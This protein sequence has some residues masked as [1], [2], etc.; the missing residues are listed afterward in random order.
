MIDV[1]R[2]AGVSPQTVSRVVNDHPNVTPHVRERVQ[3]AISQLRY[4]RN[5]AARSLVTS[6]TM[7]IGVVSWGLAQ[8]GPSVA[9]TGIA[10]AARREGYTTNLVGL[11]DTDK[12]AMRAAIG[13]LVDDHVDGIVLLAPVEAALHALDGVRTVVPLVV[14][15]PGG[16]PRPDSFAVDEVAGARI[17]TQHLLTRG[18]TKVLHLCGPPGWLATEARIRGW[19]EALTSAGLHAPIPVP[20]SWDAASGYRAAEI[21]TG[22]PDI[23]AVFVANDQTA[24]GLMAGLTERGV[25]IPDDIAVVGFDDFPEAAYFSPSLTTVRVDF[26]ALGRLAVDKILALLRRETSEAGSPVVPELVVR[27]SSGGP[28][29]HQRQ[30]GTV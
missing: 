23:T 14:F 2:L 12:A 20:T 6:R 15:E 18:H 19:R 25:R 16:V 24:L 10:E 3:W 17:A 28:D 30:E 5:P 11:A 26:A 22:Q 4:R 13:H 7:S 27:A 29:R 9:L 8:H 21:V 1:A